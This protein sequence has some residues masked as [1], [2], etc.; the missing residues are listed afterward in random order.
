MES[1]G[2]CRELMSGS[3]GDGGFFWVWVWGGEGRAAC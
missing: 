3:K 1:V 2:P